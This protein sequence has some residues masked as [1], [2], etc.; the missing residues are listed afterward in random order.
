MWHRRLSSCVQEV[1]PKADGWEE[2]RGIPDGA[3]IPSVKDMEVL[4]SNRAV[5]DI[6]LYRPADP[7]AIASNSTHSRYEEATGFGTMLVDARSAF[8]ELSWYVMLWH[9]RHACPRTSR[10]VF[11]QHRHFNTVIFQNGP[12]DDPCIIL[13]QEGIAQGNVFGLNIYGVTLTPHTNS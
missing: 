6:D 5:C 9:C 7:V 2:D 12:G 1:W 11:N 10:L 3:T 13:S 4:D 8:N